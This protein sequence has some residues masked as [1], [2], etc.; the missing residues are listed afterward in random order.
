MSDGLDGVPVQEGLWVED[1]P[2]GAPPELLIPA[3]AVA[4][5]TP[6][7][8]EARVHA[9]IEHSHHLVDVGIAEMVGDRHELAG[10]CVLW[11]GG[12]DST[13]LAHLMRGRATHAIHANTGIGIEET[14]QFVRDL[15]AT[16]SLPLLEES[17]D[18]GDSYEALVLDQGFPGPAHHFKMYQRLKERALRKA[19]S[20]LVEDGTRQRVVYLAGRRREE[21]KRRARVPEFERDGAIV[22]ISPMVLWTKIDL[23]T[24]RALHPDIPRNRVADLIHMSG[25]C[26]CG[27]FAER[28]ELSEIATWFPDVAAHIRR[29]EDAALDAGIDPERC[30]WG[31]GAY[32]SDYA[33]AR[34]A[35]PS[36]RLCDGCDAR[37]QAALFDWEEPA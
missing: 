16:W 4:A 2:G 34:A 10:V 19:R 36:G 22:W 17:P 11:S 21:S 31:W 30:R 1:V 6:D 18:P 26:L 12:N 32:R 7:Q 15:A 27:A 9:L 23:N 24:Y 14:R 37:A 5:M 13:T 20:R 35:A 28:G 33:Q 3:S 25:E 29:L 8:R